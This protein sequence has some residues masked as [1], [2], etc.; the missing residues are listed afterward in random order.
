MVKLG[1]AIKKNR[2]NKLIFLIQKFFF[3]IYSLSELDRI[4]AKRANKIDENNW[5]PYYAYRI[6]LMEDYHHPPA[7]TAASTTA[8]TTML[9]NQTANQTGNATANNNSLNG[10][11]VLTNGTNRRRRQPA[12]QATAPDSSM[13][14]SGV[15]R[16]K[17]SINVDRTRAIIGNNQNNKQLVEQIIDEEDAEN[18]EEIEN[19]QNNQQNDDMF[20]THTESTLNGLDTLKISHINGD[21]A[22]SRVTRSSRTNQTPTASSAGKA[23][24]TGMAASVVAQAALAKNSP[25]KRSRSPLVTNNNN[26][27]LADESMMS[28]ANCVLTSTRIEPHRL[29]RGAAAAAV[30]NKARLATLNK[31]VNFNMTELEQSGDVNE[32]DL[33]MES[34]AKRKR[35]SEENSLNEIENNSTST[36]K[37]NRV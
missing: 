11:P 21:S 30:S 5:Q 27:T 24:G 10:A 17:G 4:Y 16:L 1:I 19:I 8:A 36:R 35:K 37:S 28:E 23:N 33:S 15:S 22:A 9:A 34:P 6:S 12:A 29:S 7:V 31:Q 32:T 13:N 14:M 20:N 3:K 2:F 25:N 18:D 26:N